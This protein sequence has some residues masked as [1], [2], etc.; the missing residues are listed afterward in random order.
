M[1]GFYRHSYINIK[2]SFSFRG[3]HW[4]DSAAAS[5]KGGLPLLALPFRFDS[6]KCTQSMWAQMGLQKDQE[7]LSTVEETKD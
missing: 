5:F 7:V 6:I 1:S 2:P 3:Q 4:L